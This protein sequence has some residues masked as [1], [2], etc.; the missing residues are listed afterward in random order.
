MKAKKLI[1][2]GCL[3]LPLSLLPLTGNAESEALVSRKSTLYSS[4]N[5]QESSMPSANDNDGA[6]LNKGGALY[7]PPPEGG[8]PTGGSAPVGGNEV[9]TF[10]LIAGTYGIYCFL[11]KRE[12]RSV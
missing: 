11:K 6:I 8:E 9:A 12:K 1:I 3:I 5:V 10:L 2:T 7:A 4:S